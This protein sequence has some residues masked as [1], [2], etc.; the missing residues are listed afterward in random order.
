MGKFNPEC[1]STFD[2]AFSAKILKR[3]SAL[4]TRQTALLP[5]RSAMIAVSSMVFLGSAFST[6]A[7]VAGNQYWTGNP[8]WNNFE[9]TWEDGSQQLGVWAG[10]NAIFSSIPGVPNQTVTLTE[11]ISAGSLRFMDD[12]F[13]LAGS[14][15]IDLNKPGAEIEV[16]DGTATFETVLRANGSVVK[17][18]Q[19]TLVLGE[20]LTGS[21]IPQ[22]VLEAGTLHLANLNSII[23]S[24]RIDFNGGNLKFGDNNVFG[25]PPL[26]ASFNSNSANIDISN[27]LELIITLG[28]AS[29]KIIKE[30]EG[31]LNFV[32]APALGKF[33]GADVKDGVLKTSLNYFEPNSQIDVAGMLVIN[34]QTNQTYAGHINSQLNSRTN[35]FGSVR[36]SDNNILTYTG[37]SNASWIIDGG[38]LVTQ[39]GKISGLVTNNSHLAIQ[40]NEFSTNDFT[41]VTGSGDV[42]FG[43]NGNLNLYGT[44]MHTGDTFV[45]SGTVNLTGIANLPFSRNMTV[46]GGSNLVVSNGTINN[47]TLE[48]GSTLTHNDVGGRFTVSGN[49]NAK[50]GSTLSFGAGTPNGIRRL[51]ISG[52][53][54]IDNAILNVY[55]SNAQSDGN[56]GIGHYR[57]IDYSGALNGTFGYV[58]IPRIN[59]A[60]STL[61]YGAG[62]IDLFIA[63][64]G[65]NSLQYWNGGDGTWNSTI[66]S[67]INNGGTAP[68][69]W[70]GKVAIFKD[71]QTSLGGVVNVDGVQSFSGIQFV[72]NGYTLSGAGLLLIQPSGSEIRVLADSATIN[73]MIVGSGALSKTE[74]GTLILNANNLYTGDTTIYGG[75]VQVSSDSNLG[76]GDVILAGG[77]LTVAGEIATNRDFRVQQQGT[78]NVTDGN[79]L[80]ANGVLSGNGDFVKD[81]KG[82]LILNGVN[83]ITGDIGIR[84]GELKVNKDSALG[85]VSNDIEFMGGKLNTTASFATSRNFNLTANGDFNVNGSTEF[86]VNGNIVGPN[87]LIKNGAGTLVLNGTNTFNNFNVIDGSVVGNTSSISGDIRNAGIV[88]FLVAGTGT[89]NGN[90]QGLNSVDGSMIKDGSGSLTLGGVSLLDWSVK[91]GELIVDA[92]KFG[93]DINI[94]TNGTAVFNQVTNGTLAG[95]LT[96]TGTLVKEGDGTLFINGDYSSFDGLVKIA[97]GGLNTGT[98]GNLGMLGGSMIVENGA[99]LSG[100]GTIGR[101]ASSMITVADGGILAPGNSIGTLTVNGNLLL[102]NGSIYTVETDPLSTDSDRVIVTGDATIKGGTVAH[103]GFAGDYALNTKYT[104]L[105]SNGKLSGSFGNVTSEFAFLNPTLLYDYISGSVQ[106]ELARNETAFISKGTTSNHFAVA[107]ALDGMGSSS[108]VYNA[109]VK[110][111]DNAAIIANGL[112]SL[113]GEIYGSTSS[114]LIEESHYIR[115]IV[116]NRM[117][118]ALGGIVMKDD[119]SSAQ[120]DHEWSAWAQAYGGWNKIN[121]NGNYSDVKRSTGGFLVGVDTIAENGWLVGAFAGYSNSTIKADARASSADVDSFH[122]GAYAAKEWD[123]NIALRLGVANSWHKIDTERTAA[124]LGFGPESL[125]S[126]ANART[127]QAFG[128]VA[129]KIHTEKITFE[130]YSNFAYINHHMGSYNEDGGSAYLRGSKSKTSAVFGTVGI[131]AKTE[132]KLGANTKATISAGVG[133]R[134]ASNSVR[135]AASHSFTGS[136]EFTVYGAPIAKDAAILEAGLDI[137]VSKKSNFNLNYQAQISSKSTSHTAGARF[138]IKF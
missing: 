16:T 1:N 89:Y 124:F 74:A 45:S 48:G 31:S 87:D 105:Q 17:K 132:V 33:V 118:G 112:D 111:P 71:T 127:F 72:D 69:I 93:G 5:V 133:Y 57:L 2:N 20:F 101:G 15:L 35:T 135:G 73:T 103:I 82:T 85:D 29:G 84:E 41:F 97:N 95:S 44:Y 49:M 81:G 86:T 30:G 24:S 55:Q 7:Q 3:F 11:I 23:S 92:N 61:Q 47:L 125:T 119:N 130:P 78:I 13:R 88:T 42:A 94:E 9:T 62:A 134:R 28:S 136:N 46:S 51:S 27:N 8:F 76:T 4:L 25:S 67:W 108:D 40:G 131:R 12:G 138:V 98:T 106:L 50:A 114:A 99:I 63:T 19:G 60:T 54:T 90:I 100:V 117:R 65:D 137:A 122:I 121:G 56:L 37:F 75:D 14:G 26:L 83:T 39:A 120:I 79:T 34:N 110:L 21:Y 59:D 43:T 10:N 66:P 58:N 52:D 113:S 129:Y 116:N 36:K 96:G 128:E 64:S 70:G 18:G 22:W 126:D 77:A 115:D 68:D 6:S 109:F 80:A 53:L 32:T 102:A 107:N 123:N 104:I 91:Q 38:T